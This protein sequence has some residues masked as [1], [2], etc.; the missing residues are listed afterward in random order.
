MSKWV[1]GEPLQ[2]NS[3]GEKGV[4]ATAVL[5]S[6]LSATVPTRYPQFSAGQTAEG[7]FSR[8]VL[9]HSTPKKDMYDPKTC[10]LNHRTEKKEKCK[11]C[12]FSNPFRSS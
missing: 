12:I 1:F 4:W 6:P 3:T 9:L 10:S 8:P 7:M 2:L 11:A 5:V